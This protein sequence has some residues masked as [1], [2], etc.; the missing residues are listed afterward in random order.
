MPHE[1]NDFFFFVPLRVGTVDRPDWTL[2]ATYL[3][4]N[5]SESFSESFTR[6]HVLQSMNELHRRLVEV[7]LPSSVCEKFNDSIVDEVVVPY[8]KLIV[9][10]Q[11]HFPLQNGKVSPEM[12]FSWQDSFPTGEKSPG[13]LF[14]TKNDKRDANSVASICVLDSNIEIFS[15]VYNLG[16]AYSALAADLANTG[17]P[18]KI[19]LGFKRFQQAAG[20]FQLLEDAVASV[21]ADSLKNINELQ[22]A[23]VTS[24]KKLSLAQ[25]H[26]C[27][28]LSAKLTEKPGSLLSKL[29]V[30]AAEMYENVNLRKTPLFNSAIGKSFMGM[31]E[32]LVHLFH[33]RSH[34]HLALSAE[35]D[36]EMGLAIAHCHECLKRLDLISLSLLP[37]SFKEWVETF[38]GTSSVI[39]SRMEKVNN[40]VCY[41]AIRT[42][43]PSPLGL[44]K[45]LG[46][47]ILYPSSFL[48]VEESTKENDPFWGIIAPTSDFMDELKS[49]RAEV[50][51]L[52]KRSRDRAAKVQESVSSSFQVLGVDTYASMGNSSVDEL[53]EHPIPDSICQKLR[54]IHE[55]STN[56]DLVD[57]L[58]E[59]FKYVESRKNELLAKLA[60][61]EK[62]L[63]EN[64]VA[65]DA[66]YLQ[67]YGETLWRSE[68][69]EIS[70]SKAFLSLI[71]LL[72]DMKIHI[73]CSL[74]TNLVEAKRE[75]YVQASN[76]S[77]VEMT[78]EKL[79]ILI[80]S[81]NRNQEFIELCKELEGLIEEKRSIEQKQ[82]EALTAAKCIVES[83]RLIKKLTSAAK[84]HQEVIFSQET[85]EIKNHLFI[86]DKFNG[87]LEAILRKAEE[88]LTTLAKIQ[89]TDASAM[90]KDRILHDL[91]VGIDTYLRVSTS[92][93][94]ALEYAQR[95]TNRVGEILSSIHEFNVAQKVSIDGAK[96][97]LD[98]KIS[99]KMEILIPSDP[100]GGGNH[101]STYCPPATSPY[102]FQPGCVPPLPTSCPAQSVYTDMY[103]TAYPNHPTTPGFS[104]ELQGFQPG[105]NSS[106]PPQYQ[107][108]YDPQ[109][110][111]QGQ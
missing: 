78:P 55:Q 37:F 87:E 81:M 104:T 91:V 60:E 53:Q 1:C 68:F 12:A 56:K 88:K 3:K 95:Y 59:Q 47:P 96:S 99:Q 73:I 32:A 61:G 16:A 17:D 39:L 86:A 38:R 106:V 44:P 26:H 22:K 97:R 67:Q 98:V 15:C 36:T 10:A 79:G 76:V 18:G 64:V 100:A 103:S 69:P 63:R 45:A 82:G 24:L 49:W 23:S 108:Y 54:E 34:L 107:G 46:A 84:Q 89:S 83:D 6:V 19:K 40:V 62:I 85:K 25:A 27:S 20:F 105:S 70:K 65:C 57:T 92:V 30:K 93:T 77:L 101:Q 7:F 94:A 75:M 50:Q 102:Y 35:E 111:Q 21:P 72:Q 58:L 42:S 80:P 90:E 33:S 52:L 5:F 66:P 14:G 2:C 74:E 41:Q 28:Y 31:T 71:A 11:G 9:Q 4:K 48:Q 110:H 8:C 13:S 43:V 29:C 109:W 51:E